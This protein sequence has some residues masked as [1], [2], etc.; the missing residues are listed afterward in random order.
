MDLQFQDFP[1]WPLPLQI[2][3]A[4]I[5]ILSRSCDVSFPNFSM[6]KIFRNVHDDEC[7][8]ELGACLKFW[9]LRF[10]LL[11]QK[12]GV[13][14]SFRSVSYVSTGPRSLPSFLFRV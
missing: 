8:Q 14:R 1:L 4:D 10:L 9:C 5:E 2:M 13:I 3:L 11:V 7:Q 6:V 12:S